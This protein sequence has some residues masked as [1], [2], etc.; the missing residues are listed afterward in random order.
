MAPAESAFVCASSSLRVGRPPCRV[1]KQV[2]DLLESRVF[3]E[4]VHIEAAVDEA[5][6]APVDETDLRGRN[7]DIL[8]A[9]LEFAAHTLPSPRGW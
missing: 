3:D 1:P 9:R 6:L 5:P 8:E 4:I 2:D 7:D